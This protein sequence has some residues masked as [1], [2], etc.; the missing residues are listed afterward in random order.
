MV[1]ALINY[2]ITAHLTQADLSLLN[3]F[4]EI[5]KQK[6]KQRRIDYC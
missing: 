5:K 3:D 2:Y 6:L 1:T 4:D